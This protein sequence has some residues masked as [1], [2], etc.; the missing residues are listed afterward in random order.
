M[1]Q[2]NYLVAL[3][4]G[5][6]LGIITGLLAYYF[7]PTRYY[8]TIEMKLP[9]ITDVINFK[10]LEL[11]PIGTVL[12][13][14]NS[15]EFRQRV[16]M[17]TGSNDAIKILDEDICNNCM[18]VKS[19]K[20]SDVI[21]LTIVTKEPKLGLNVAS[22]LFSEIKIEQDKVLEDI[23]NKLENLTDFDKQ[24]EKLKCPQNAIIIDSKNYSF[25]KGLII[26]KTVLLNPIFVK[27]NMVLK[28]L[29]KTELF[30]VFFGIII[31]Y[32]LFYRKKIIA[33]LITL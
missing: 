30:S 3:W 25:Y 9:N 33:Y 29:L 7:Q 12:Q 27:K 31:S 28:D 14:I 24:L 22:T 11:E 20:D 18:R 19:Y 21:L 1:F 2:K 4:T 23:H 10:K 16:S 15:N 26:S 13:R 8:T 6:L 5:I 17:K 32:L